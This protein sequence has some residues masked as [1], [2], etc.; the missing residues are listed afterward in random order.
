V[1]LLPGKFAGEH[2]P[3]RLN[4]QPEIKMTTVTEQ[5]ELI[6]S[7][8]NDEGACSNPEILTVGGLAKKHS[9]EILLG[10]AADGSWRVGWKWNNGKHSDEQPLQEMGEPHGGRMEAV[11]SALL[12]VTHYF[13]SNKTSSAALDAFYEAGFA[14]EGVAKPASAG[15][16]ADL[17]APLPKWKF[18]ELPVSAI[19]PNPENHRKH[20]D[21]M[22]AKELADSIKQ[23]GLLQPIAVRL[24]GADE[25]GEMPMGGEGVEAKQ[26]EIILGHRRHRAHIVLG[27]PTI[28]AMVYE[29]VSRAD[30]KAAALIENLQREDVNPIEEA[31]GYAD[32]MATWNLTTAQCADRVGR[33]RPSVAN[34]LRV[35]EVPAVTELIREGEL[36]MAHGMALHKYA[37]RPEIVKI[38][39]EQ[40]VLHSTSAGQLEEWN[41][42]N[43]VP[44][45]RELA[46]AG[47]IAVI[48]RSDL[49][50]GYGTEWPEA[51]AT[52][53]DYQD[54][55]GYSWICWAP[56][57]AREFLDTWKAELAEAKLKAD[58]KTAKDRKKSGIKSLADLS[59]KDYER[60]G[61][62][63][64]EIEALL[65]ESKVLSLKETAEKDAE[66]VAVCTAPKFAA[67]V[68]EALRQAKELDRQIQL[69][70]LLAEARA[71]L[72]KWKKLGA[73]ETAIVL[74]VL[75]EADSDD[76]YISPASAKSQ[77]VTIPAALKLAD[78]AHNNSRLP[79]DISKAI[80]A[81][82]ADPVAYARVIVDDYLV[83]LFCD[84]WSWARL[85]DP[86][87]EDLSF[88]GISESGRALL[89]TVLDKPLGLLEDSA[90]GRRKLVAQVKALP[91]Y[92]AAFEQASKAGEDMS[93]IVEEESAQAGADGEEAG[94][95]E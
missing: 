52:D 16:V 65:P 33:P 56:A 61:G 38:M 66:V 18:A 49:P 46:K 17:A 85:T 54:V 26:Y 31:E 39:A 93:D 3:F 37:A 35:L 92:A 77:G 72:K 91:W 90:A 30:A 34:A 2:L 43:Y 58:E 15:E 83:G 7:V 62:N 94:D 11:R 21:A 9:V 6:A 50:G 32:L 5:P 41:K 36:T 55:D 86:A 87:D 47:I 28:A 57:K 68:S 20:H 82:A 29:G 25:L 69:P 12:A 76:A 24:L 42:Q 63:Q 13:A 14:A 89:A 78:Y 8:W 4:P 19:S 88:D 71:K 40:C 59:R 1:A 75:M 48:H 53:A 51:W 70:L 81:L 84:T 10:V 67:A 74:A 73:A 60:I 27:L 44:F 95:N 22:K 79:A 45:F 80:K 64:S 23:A